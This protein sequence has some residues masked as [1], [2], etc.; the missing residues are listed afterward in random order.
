[1]RWLLV[2]LLAACT[3]V[4]RDG[5]DAQGY[6]WERAGPVGKPTVHRSQDVYLRCGLEPH[7]R[8]CA[9]IEG[10]VCDVYLP[11]D[12]EPWMEPHELRHCAGWQHPS[13]F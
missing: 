9:R 3:A 8:S 6:R 11:P 5:P 1:M 2:A 7:A 12:P 4:E 13:P 10:G